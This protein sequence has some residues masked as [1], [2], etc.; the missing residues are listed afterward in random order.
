MSLN[1]SDLK[2]NCL[3]KIEPNVKYRGKLF[4][5]MLYHC[6]NWTFRLKLINGKPYLLDNYYSSGSN[7]SIEVTEEVLSETSLILNF[8]TVTEIKD[9][10]E[11]LYNYDDVYRVRLGS[12]GNFSYFINKDTNI[13]NEL[14]LDYL[15]SEIYSVE[16]KLKELLL[17]KDS[18]VNNND[19]PYNLEYLLHKKRY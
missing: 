3:Y 14:V 9:Y 7:L 10:K 2:E 13:N 5:N 6:C 8:D 16:D 17:L 19:I 4:D 1:L 15:N 11:H 12:S 18:V